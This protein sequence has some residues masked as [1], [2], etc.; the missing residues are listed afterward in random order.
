M[1]IKNWYK[2]AMEEKEFYNFYAFSAI[3]DKVFQENPEIL[4]SFINILNNLRDYYLA[5]LIKEIA[6]EVGYALDSSRVFPQISNIN[7]EIINQINWQ[8]I[9]DL[10]DDL[11]EEFQI[12]IERKMEMEERNDKKAKISSENYEYIRLLTSYAVENLKNM[13]NKEVGLKIASD[14]FGGLEWMGAFGGPLWQRITKETIKLYKMGEINQQKF[15][16]TLMNK[17]RSTVLYLDT[18]N[19]LEH[20]TSLVLKDMPDGEKEWL[21]YALEIVKHG[22]PENIASLSKNMEIQKIYQRAITPLYNQNSERMSNYEL[23]YEA[24][25]KQISLSATKNADLEKLNVILDIFINKDIEIAGAIQLAL[26]IQSLFVN[27]NFTS[28]KSLMEKFLQI[29]YPL[30]GTDIDTIIRYA[31]SISFFIK[32]PQYIVRFLSENSSISKKELYDLFDFYVSKNIFMSSQ[33]KEV[34]LNKLQNILG[35]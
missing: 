25:S 12:N 30:V 9:S 21:F 31:L 1:K 22:N 3:P 7:F 10:I 27:P 23:M 4:Y 29:R 17:I 35:I 24:F 32:E 11:D 28:N 6:G 26:I 18:I 16:N 14:L 5:Y 8:N 13:E 15:S 19:S 33:Y 2:I 34:T 20:N